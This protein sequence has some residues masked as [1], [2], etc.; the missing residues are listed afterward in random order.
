MQQELV[1]YYFKF[2][3][4]IILIYCYQ[5]IL[6]SKYTVPQ[7]QHQIYAIYLL[8]YLRNETNTVHSARV[9]CLRYSLLA[10]C[11]HYRS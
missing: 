6:L 9:K 3:T 10:L 8:N 5:N 7:L 4:I 2:Y 1:A 11:V